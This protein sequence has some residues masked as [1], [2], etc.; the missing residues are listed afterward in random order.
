MLCLE[1]FGGAGWTFDTC[2]HVCSPNKQ[3]TIIFLKIYLLVTISQRGMWAHIHINALG[4]YT[5]TAPNH[6]SRDVAVAEQELCVK[7]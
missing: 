7:A 5:E 6:K 4:C 2:I 3:G 1:D